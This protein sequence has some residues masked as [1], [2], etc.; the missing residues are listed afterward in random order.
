MDCASTPENLQEVSRPPLTPQAQPIQKLTKFSISI[1]T[2]RVWEWAW[3]V[4]AA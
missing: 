2:G 3:Q 4:R 1:S